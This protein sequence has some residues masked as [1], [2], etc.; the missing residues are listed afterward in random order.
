MALAEKHKTDIVSADSRQI[1]KEMN[2]GV[3]RPSDNDLQKVKHYCVAH[4]NVFSNYSTGDFVRDCNK[5]LQEIFT[6]KENAIICGGTGLYIKALLHGLDT[7]PEVSQQV[8]EQLN[9]MYENEGISALQQLL[10]EKDKAYF[11]QVDK[12]NPRRIIR[13]LEICFSGD[14]PYSFFLNKKEHE[15]HF[16]FDFY[17]LNIDKEKLHQN[18]EKRVDVMVENGLVDEVQ[19]LLPY[20]NLQALQTVGYRELFDYFDGKISLQ[21]AIE[22]IKIHTKQYAKRQLTWLRKQEHTVWIKNPEE[23]L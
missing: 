1:Y 13:A 9:Y 4:T 22:L 16:P 3:A 7:F 11:E 5:H 10:K 23:I 18:I 19:A 14:K 2:I 20:R 8:R 21:Q 17:V 15:F 12:Q 6:T